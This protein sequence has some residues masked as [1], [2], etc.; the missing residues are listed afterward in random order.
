[1][2]LLS[3][4]CIAGYHH[5]GFKLS[6]DSNGDRVFGGDVIG[7]LTFELAQIRVGPGTVPISI[8]LCIDARYI[9]DPHPAHMQ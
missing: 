8:V 1:V 5:I 4:E 9:K 2:K 6:T 3:N 7:S